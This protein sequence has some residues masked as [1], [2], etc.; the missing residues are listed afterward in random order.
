MKAIKTH[1]KNAEKIKRYLLRHR[2][3]DRSYRVFKSN[4]FIYF[5]MKECKAAEIRWL[6]SN[7]A[8]VADVKLEKSSSKNYRSVLL[9]LVGARRYKRMAKSYDIVGNIATIDKNRKSDALAIAK[10]IMLTNKNVETVLMKN[11]AVRGRYR[12]RSYAYV[13]GKKNYV[14]VYKENGATFKFDV[15]ET[16]FSTRLAYERARITRSARD[17]ENVVV[18]FAGVGPFAIEIA[19]AHRHSTV[20]AIELNRA[21]YEYLCENIAIN[22]LTNVTAVHGDV[23]K[24]SK[25]Y[26]GFADRIIMPLPK[27]SHEF[28]YSAFEVAKEKATVHYYAFGKANEAV[29]QNIKKITDF[30]SKLNCGV[31]ILGS[32]VVRPYSSTEIE[33]VIDFEIQK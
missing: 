29:I 16:F 5:P 30:F 12:K 26:R 20:V 6:R 9:S 10:A 32:R 21:A 4:S 17:Y 23:G 31:T 7:G 22:R 8:V 28:L 33:I 2:I 11:S 15:R 25:D 24:V 1:R 27:T 19:K 14:A 13:L 18:M 3:F